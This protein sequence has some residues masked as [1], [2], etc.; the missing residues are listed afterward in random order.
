MSQQDFE[1][2]PVRGRDC[3]CSQVSLLAP[4]TFPDVFCIRGNGVVEERLKTLQWQEVETVFS[5]LPQGMAERAGP[6][7]VSSWVGTGCG[8]EGLEDDFSHFPGKSYS[9]RLAPLL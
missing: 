5:R 6:A 1:L 8:S 3:V 9:S 7:C 2:Q 4:Y